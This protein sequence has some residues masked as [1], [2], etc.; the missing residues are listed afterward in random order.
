MLAMNNSSY[1]FTELKKI[2]SDIVIKYQSRADKYELADINYAREVDDYITAV[3]GTDEFATHRKYSAEAVMLSGLTDNMQLALVYAKDSETI[4][5]EW[6]E[7]VHNAQRKVTIENYV[8]RNQYYRTLAGLPP[9]DMDPLNYA[10]GWEGFY[11]EYDLPFVPVHEL[12]D[13]YLD[14]MRQSPDWKDL[15]AMYNPYKVEAYRYLQHL[16][17]LKVDYYE[18]RQAT[19]FDIINIGNNSVEP[20]VMEDFMLYYSQNRQYVLTVLFKKEYAYK[21]PYYE[22]YMAMMLMVMTI[23]RVIVN[24]FK[25]GIEREFYDMRTLKML[26]D[27][28]NIPFIEEVPINYQRAIAKNLNK[29]LMYKS[30][31]KVI[32]DVSSLLGFDKLTVHKY[33]LVKQHRYDN[34]GLPVFIYTKDDNGDLVLDY[35]RMYDIYF[36]SMDIQEKDIGLGMKK[37]SNKVSYDSVVDSDIQWWK[38]DPE[39]QRRLYETDYNYIETKYLHMNVMYKLT[40]ML[41][42]TSTFIRMVL[43]NPKYTMKVNL[44][45]PKLSISGTISYYDAIVTLSTLLCYRNRLKGNLIYGP[46]KTLAVLGFNFKER[47]SILKEYSSKLPKKLRTDIDKY[48]GV[49]NVSSKA[50]INRALGNIEDFREYLTKHMRYTNDLE[51]YRTLKDMYDGLL[52]TEI[53]EST[54]MKRDGTP[55]ET[56]QELLLDRRPD[57]HDKIFSLDPKEDSETLKELSEHIIYRLQ[58]ELDRLTYM[59]YLEPDSNVMVDA[60][61]TM[62]RFFKS[63]T[64]DLKEFN[65]LYMVDSKYHNMIKLIDYMKGVDIEALMKDET[66]RYH[67]K[68]I[69]SS[70]LQTEAFELLPIEERGSFI[71]YLMVHLDIINRMDMNSTNIE[72]AVNIET[73]QYKDTISNILSGAMVSSNLNPIEKMKT[74]QTHGTLD[75]INLPTELNKVTDG[76]ELSSLSC[77]YNDT[78]VEVSSVN[79]HSLN[80]ISDEKTEFIHHYEISEDNNYRGDVNDIREVITHHSRNGQYHDDIHHVEDTIS[81]QDKIR[82]DE[83][84]NATY[85]YI[86]KEFLRT[87]NQIYQTRV[88][89][90]IEHETTT[91]RDI[92][93]SIIKRALLKGTVNL[94]SSHRYDVKQNLSTNCNLTHDVVA[95]YVGH[96]NHILRI[97]SV[98]TSHGQ[99]DLPEEY[100]KTSDNVDIIQYR[101]Y[102]SSVAETITDTLCTSIILH[103]DGHVRSI[104]ELISSV[105]IQ[106]ADN[107]NFNG[108]IYDSG[109][110]HHIGNGIKLKH[111]VS[112]TRTLEA[113]E[114]HR[115]R[116]KIWIVRN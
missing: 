51:V 48:I 88:S 115:L 14:I 50:D 29:L 59:Y 81:F 94:D 104:D 68:D 53:N 91:Y 112:K 6:R 22:E 111:A 56:I 30:S 19:N 36:M 41:F 103:L 39:L 76:I 107:I 49:M 102:I 69:L 31:D 82:I 64:V 95:S 2:M 87:I 110:S 37:Q 92:I 38:D 54:Y 33:M 7:R 93:S 66:L 15:L 4:P 17:S 70:Y 40:E 11:E 105:T 55:A 108:G 21:Y 57:I 44:S 1:L 97:T 106:L 75:H 78:V 35:E 79:N 46:T 109:S 28:Y 89:M 73:G 77:N 63:Y 12:D 71:S 58:D 32:Y 27:C 43:D 47:L 16:G 67:Y 5:V 85:H 34:E 26:F 23:Q 18:A 62:I 72:T 74:E 24:Q 83:R 114:I 113:G 90:H 86:I 9:I 101:N 96:V 10:Y 20:K 52:V 8:E 100:I 13:H 98:L 42:Q 80:M 99:V 65:V 45:L 116:E 60:L 61:R 3:E 25:N 84:F